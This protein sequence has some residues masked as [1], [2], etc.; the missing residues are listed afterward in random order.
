MALLAEMR[1]GPGKCSD[2]GRTL[3]PRHLG[4]HSFYLERLKA[5][6]FGAEDMVF[7][8]QRWLHGGPCPK[9]SF[10]G[11]AIGIR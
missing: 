11:T 7:Q 10:G 8:M 5:R 4:R 1:G 3:D 9:E 6:K 2:C